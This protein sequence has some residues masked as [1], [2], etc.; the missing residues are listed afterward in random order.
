MKPALNMIA[1]RRALVFAGG[2][3]AVVGAGALIG[4]GDGGARGSIGEIDRRKISA[5]G[6]GFYLA[7][8][9]VLTAD[10]LNSMGLPPPA[11]E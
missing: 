10:D 2:A 11:P 8:G 3:A 6:D 9:W 4:R 5:L 7:D 1:S